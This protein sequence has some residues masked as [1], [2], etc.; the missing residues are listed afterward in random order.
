[1]YDV[2]IIGAGPSGCTAARELA[3]SGHKVLLIEKFRLPRN[4]SCSGILIRKSMDLIRQY[5]GEDVPES[6]MCKPFDNRGMILTNDRGQEYRF[7]QE[8]LNIWRNSFDYWLAAK[9]ARAGAE[10]RDETAAISCE[11][12]EKYVLV[13][14]RGTSTYSEKA[15]AVIVCDGVV[16]SV[17]RKL[18]PARQNYVT[19]Y[20][21]FNKGRIDLDRHYFYAW[22]QPWLSEYDAWFN[23]KDDYLILGVAVKDICKLEHYY[24][25]FI[26][27]MK[28]HHNAI[29]EKQ[30]KAEKWL[31]PHIMPKCPIDYGKGRVLF[32]G[33]TAGFLNPMG[34]GIS[35]G[36]ESG[37]AAAKAIEQA[38]LDSVPDLKALHQ[39][40]ISST[41]VLRN[42]ME[43]QWNFVANISDSFGY[44]KL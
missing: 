35:A 27:Y 9:A 39:A 29:I 42:Y 26:S 10:I 12:Q 8:G 41:A 5:F 44:M 19:T 3:C 21:T 24:S 23:V 2:I 6:V 16:G 32:A 31:M 11:E 14:L 7:E 15:K 4:K 43:R 36:M 18:L 1:M 22:L 28:K 25:E 34:E 13:N 38:G 40:Y 33:E 37:H 30:E 17:K 20:Q